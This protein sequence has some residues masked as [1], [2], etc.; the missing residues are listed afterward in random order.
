[1]AMQACI[2][3][4]DLVFPCLFLAVMGSSV[5][6]PCLCLALP[7]IALLCLVRFLFR[8]RPF[9]DSALQ[10]TSAT[11]QETVVG[12]IP[13]FHSYG[14]V[15]VLLSLLLKG[16]RLITMENYEPELILQVIENYKVFSIIVK[17]HGHYVVVCCPLFYHRDLKL[18]LYAG[19]CQNEI[20][21]NFDFIC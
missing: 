17:V 1:M 21:S 20:K 2:S 5:S 8:S 16:Y 14:L 15:C 6:L 7:C 10:H 18:Y 3:M 4:P 19:Q 12:F 13:F 11:H 9:D